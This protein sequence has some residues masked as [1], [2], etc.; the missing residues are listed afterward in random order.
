V[1]NDN[2]PA[3]EVRD[4]AQVTQL[5]GKNIPFSRVGVAHRDKG[6]PVK[7]IVQVPVNA[8][9][10]TDM[11]IQTSDDDPGIIAPFTNC[12][13]NG[14]FAEF[15]LKDDMLKKLRSAA[16]VGKVS[17]ADAGGRPVAVPISFNGFNA[18]FDALTKRYK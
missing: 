11:R 7:L 8:S 16:S 3:A 4:M 13:P 5:Q 6:Q 9:F 17:F 15:A 1:T 14:C 10:A 12:T 18:A 2:P